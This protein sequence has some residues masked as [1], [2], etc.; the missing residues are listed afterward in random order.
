MFDQPDLEQ[1]PC[2]GLAGL[3]GFT[4]RGN[5]EVTGIAQDETGARVEMTD[6]GTDAR[7]T[8]HAE[9]VLGCDGANSLTRTAIGATLADLK[10]DR[11]W[12]VVDIA[13]TADLGQWEGVHQVCDARRAATYM[14][15]GKTRY[16]WE[17]RLLPGE[18]GDDFHSLDR[19]YPLIA[20]WTKDIPAGDLEIVRG[21]RSSDRNRRPVH[22]TT[23]TALSAGSIHTRRRR[24]TSNPVA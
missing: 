24:S 6:R 7:E 19:L 13:T 3:D 22:S 12:L 15:F 4:L 17:S 16:R 9:H 11:R 5:T 1:L 8:I 21:S 18:T 10:F 2:T 20:P 23:A 14:R